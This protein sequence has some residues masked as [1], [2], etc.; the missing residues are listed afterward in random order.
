MNRQ[1]PEKTIST[2]ACDSI[3]AYK[4]S[5]ERAPQLLHR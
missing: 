2:I 5:H 1:Y 3:G 4:V